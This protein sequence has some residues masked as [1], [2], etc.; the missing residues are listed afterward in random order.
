MFVLI[1]GG[2]R[3]GTQ[4]AA[5]LE[6][7]NHEVHVVE[8]RREVLT[9]AHRELPTEVIFEGYPTDLNMLD[10]AGIRRAD[11]VAACTS[12]AHHCSHQLSAQRLVI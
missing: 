3:T 11:A 9:L 1:A 2:G 5:L 6:A 8:G 12:E 7:Q 10:Q 4:L